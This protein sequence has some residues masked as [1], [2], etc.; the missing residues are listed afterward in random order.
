MCG[1]FAL[2][3]TPAILEEWMETHVGVEFPPLYNIG[4]MQPIIVIFNTIDGPRERKAMLMRWGLMPVWV[5]DPTDFPLLINARAE[6]ILEKPSFRGGLRHHR[7]IIPASGYY[8]WR[9]GADGKKQPHYIYRA[10]G[11][12]LALAG[13]YSTW[14]GADGS[15]IDTVA[16]ITVAAS[17]DLKHLHERMPAIISDAQIDDWLDVDNVGERDAHKMLVPAPEGT[18][19]F[20]P[21]STRVGSIRNDDEALID[22]VTEQAPE[23]PKK[24][25]GQMDL[26]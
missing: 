17:P 22:P 9:K 20:H 24:A 13:V 10:D 2:T 21:V 19:A 6:T 4:P 8:E 7:C 26:F 18:M 1:R 14:M 25:G 5:K 11:K 16:I 15:E 23:P 3:V 12:P